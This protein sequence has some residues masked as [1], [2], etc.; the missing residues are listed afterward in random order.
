MTYN[1]SSLRNMKLDPQYSYSPQDFNFGGMAEYPMETLSSFPNALP[2]QYQGEMNLGLD[3]LQNNFQ[4]GPLETNL[5]F[6]SEPNLDFLN[7]TKSPA[8]FK[9]GWNAGTGKLASFGLG[10]LN[11]MFGAY[12]ANKARKLAQN[13]FAFQKEV[14][15]INLNNQIKSYNTALEDRQR[16]RGAMAGTSEAE[17]QA[18]IDKHKMTR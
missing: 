15:N 6:L 9:F 11:S 18:Y 14:G 2:N 5:D 4:L 7:E 16:L 12:N 13:Q 1:L 10:V 17:T 8:D 3:N